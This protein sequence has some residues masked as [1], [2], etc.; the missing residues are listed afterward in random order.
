MQKQHDDRGGAVPRLH[1]ETVQAFSDCIASLTITCSSDTEI[2]AVNKHDTGSQASPSNDTSLGT[3]HI[4]VQ[5]STCTLIKNGLDACRTCPSA[6]GAISAEIAVHGVGEQCSVDSDCAQD[7]TCMQNSCSRQCTDASD[8]YAR[9][10]NC[11]IDPTLNNVC[12]TTQTK[13][14]CASVPATPQD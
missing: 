2:S 14:V 10:E 1:R 11:I 6:A 5:D 12:D 9:A 8:C 7:L 4:V 13:P 3:Q